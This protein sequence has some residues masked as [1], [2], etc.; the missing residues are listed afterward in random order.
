MLKD[1]SQILAGCIEVYDN[2]IPNSSDLIK[3]SENLNLWEDAKIFSKEESLVSD[4]NIRSNKIFWLKD[5]QDYYEG[6]LDQTDTLISLYLDRYNIKYDCGAREIESP[7][8]LKYVP[9]EFYVPHYDYSRVSP[10]IFSSLLYLN[11]VDEG[12]ETFF[13]HFD[14][15][16]QPRAGRLV[17][18]PSNYA[19]RHQAISPIEENKYVLV[20]WI[21]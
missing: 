4:K 21:R 15:K 16:I 1:A 6:L 10:R 12:G 19:Y 9:G 2:I 20:T 8:I 18:F 14:I 3:L 17:I 13:N 7:A 11:D 5:D